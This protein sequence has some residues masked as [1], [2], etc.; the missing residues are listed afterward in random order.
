MGN[1][2]QIHGETRYSPRLVFLSVLL[3][4]CEKI[5]A[6]FFSG[7]S[8]SACGILVGP[9]TLALPSI[10][11]DFLNLG[12][13]LSEAIWHWSFKPIF[14]RLLNKGS[15]PAGA[16]NVTTQLRQAVSLHWETC[17]SGCRQS[18]WCASLTSVDCYC[19]FHGFFSSGPSYEGSTPFGQW[20]CTPLCGT[21]LL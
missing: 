16:R 5:A 11:F 13:W 14:W 6:F 3:L 9:A 1:K 21:W 2:S 12:G 4:H 20:R 17:G 18:V 15:L 8:F 10:S 7:D 19:I